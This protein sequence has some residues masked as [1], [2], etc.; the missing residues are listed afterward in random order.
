M[1]R[2]TLT[3]VP[4]VSTSRLRAKGLLLDPLGQLR[5]RH[6][7]VALAGL[8]ELDARP[9]APA[10]GRR[11]RRLP[12][13]AVR[14]SPS[15]SCAP[16]SRAF[17]TR[18]SSSITSSVALAAAQRHDVA[19]VRAAVRAGRRGCPSARAARQDAG[20][21]QAGRDALGHDEDVRL[22]VPVL[23]REHLAGAPEPGLDLV[24]DEQD[25]VL[26]R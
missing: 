21:R 13:G 23:D 20:Q 15:S 9:S 10:R 2:I 26:A 1:I 17:A 3:Y 8:D 7:A 14:R 5:V 6:P 4:A 24:G 11:R 19:A 22:D 12:G 18:P 25:A 16:R